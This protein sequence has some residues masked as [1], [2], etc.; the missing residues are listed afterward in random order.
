MTLAQ[1]DL[2][3]IQRPREGLAILTLNRP[4][5]M[6]ALSLNLRRQLT[7]AIRALDL[8]GSTSVIIL[9]GAGKAFCAGLD[10]KEMS[11]DTSALAS[12]AT[13]NPISAIHQF[14]G[15]VI[16]AINGAA[17][18]GG[19]ELALACDILIASEAAKFADTHIR[20][21]A[22]PGWELSQRLSRTIG[23]YRAKH[24]AMTGKYISAMQAEAWGI[25]S[26]VVA[27][28][29]LLS[30]AL[31]IA[32][33]MLAMPAASLKSYKRLIDDGYAVTLAEGLE[34]ERQRANTHNQAV[35]PTEIAARRTSIQ[36][37]GSNSA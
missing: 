32:D 2:L 37:H 10:L 36:H 5:A 31:A 4:N 34:I 15:I 9:T 16:G 1:Y 12:D 33:T 11:S 18:T 19:F 8:D 21:G 27:A 29:D 6:N 17:I 30:S 25:V 35:Q 28:E 3:D 14:S 22:M 13:D 20:V 7:G 23:I 26:E 24:L